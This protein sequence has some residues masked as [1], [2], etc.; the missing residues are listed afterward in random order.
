MHLQDV[1][2]PWDT[3]KC[4]SNVC[5][6][7]CNHCHNIKLFHDQI[8]E[9]CILACERTIPHTDTSSSGTVKHLAGWNE[10]VRPGREASLFWHNVW[11]ECGSLRNAAVA[12]VMR[13][14]RAEY[15]RAVRYVKKN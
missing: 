1:L 14:A 5:V 15:H 13:R 12:D 9:C 10:Y 3:V 8:V 11:K 2:V 6:K 7:R 4:D